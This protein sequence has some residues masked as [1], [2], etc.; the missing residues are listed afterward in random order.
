MPVNAVGREIPREIDG[1]KLIPFGGAYARKPEGRLH[2]P[3]IPPLIRPGESKVLP[4]LDDAIEKAGITDGM[5]L[6]FHHH[7]RDGDLLVNMVL[8]KLAK[9]GIKDLKMAHIALFPVHEPLVK[10]IENGVITSTEGSLNGPTGRA[11]SMGKLKGLATLRSHGG[12]VRAVKAGEIE[13]DVNFIAAPTA[14]TYGNCN[15]FW[16]KSPC[17]PLSYAMIDAEHADTVIAVTDN[18]VQYPALPFSIPQTQVDYVTTVDNI[19]IPEKIVSGTTQITRSP[20]RLKIAR[21]AIQLIKEAGYIKDGMS[22]QAGAGGVSLAAT[23]FLGDAMR[24]EGVK[25]SFAMGGTTRYVTDMLRDGLI[26][27]IFDAQLFDLYA[28][29]SLR[30]NPKHV[31]VSSE[32]YADIHTKGTIVNRVDVSFL[33]ATEIDTDFNVNVNTHSDGWLLHGTGGHQD[34]AA[35]SDFTMILA[36]S[37]RGRV[38]IITDSVTTVTTPGETID[39]IVTERG[40][41]INPRREDILDRLHG[42]TL[43]IMPI[44]DLMKRVRRI[45]G[46][47][48]KPEFEDRIVAVIEYRDGTVIDVVRQKKMK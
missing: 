46:V 6:S 2:A 31:E 33:G 18:L 36:P 38:P 1:K 35:G 15:G 42:S 28:L 23:K 27:T 7:F 4:S 13:I 29:D 17:G 24:K 16:G 3:K 37:F 5:T 40:I 44:E 14:D 21:Q 30:N 12:R 19:G 41:A 9:K 20:A 45:T 11:I 25:G 43:P 10:Y 47:P 39:A 32:M 22:F 8:E 34:V 26:D 48:K